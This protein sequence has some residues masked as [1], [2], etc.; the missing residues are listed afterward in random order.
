MRTRFLNHAVCEMTTAAAAVPATRIRTTT[1]TWTRRRA[2]R[3]LQHMQ[4]E[5]LKG[6]QNPQSSEKFRKLCGLADVSVSVGMLEGLPDAEMHAPVA[7]LRRSVH[8]QAGNWIE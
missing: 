3:M 8:E 5:R 2:A 4:T 6:T 7:D 1:N